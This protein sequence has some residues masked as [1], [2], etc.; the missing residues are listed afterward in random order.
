MFALFSDEDFS[1]RYNLTVANSY[2]WARVMVQISH[3]VYV[4][5]HSGVLIGQPIQVLIPTGGAGNLTGK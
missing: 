1:R 2:N 3:F 5:L 4:Y